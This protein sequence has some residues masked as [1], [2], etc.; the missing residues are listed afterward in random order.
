MPLKKQP[1]NDNEIPIYDEALIYQRGEYWQ[2]RMW[3]TKEGKYARFSLRTR[4]RDTAID[5]AKKRYHELMAQQLAN[6]TYFSM[7]TKQGVEEYVKQ[8]QKDMEAGLIVKGRL[9]TIKTPLKSLVLNPNNLM[10]SLILANTLARSL[11]ISLSSSSANFFCSTLICS[12]RFIDC[13]L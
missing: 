2:M 5:K 10:S 9:G 13:S 11:S 6:K 4:N 1:L 12:I 3:L 8:R 7:T